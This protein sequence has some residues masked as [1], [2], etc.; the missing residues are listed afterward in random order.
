MKFSAAILLTTAFVVTSASRVPDKEAPVVD[1]D[2][3]ADMVQQRMLSGSSV[4]FA[5][6]EFERMLSAGSSA[7]FAEGDPL[8]GDF[9]R[10]TPKSSSSGLRGLAQEEPTCSFDTW[11]LSFTSK[12]SNLA[13]GLVE[14]FGEDNALS[15]SK[16]EN[17]SKST[18]E[19]MFPLLNSVH[20]L[21]QSQ[22][23]DVDDEAIVE[24]ITAQSSA[25]D[26]VYNAFASSYTCPAWLRNGDK[27]NPC[28]TKWFEAMAGVIKFPLSALG[29]TS[30]T[31]TAKRILSHMSP[32]HRCRTGE[33]I[34]G[35][36]WGRLD[37]LSPAKVTGII[38]ESTWLAMKDRGFDGVMSDINKCHSWYEWI[39]FGVVWA[40]QITATFSSAGAYMTAITLS[41][42]AY[43]MV[44]ITNILG[45]W[46][47]K[48]GY[49]GL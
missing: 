21:L 44:Y 45:G 39:V 38:V 36:D 30:P 2:E 42:V 6:G 12:E 34:A 20:E 26:D 28:Y 24:A 32:S 16:R 37:V 25:S 22:D 19:S 14:L 27:S 35:I 18:M 49:A 11:D 15:G 23:L 9:L 33:L 4:V 1:A 10:S 17:V 8:R 43:N 13:K 41:L 3:I 48:C 46:V 31:C 40:A 7:V 5:D 29:L 47:S